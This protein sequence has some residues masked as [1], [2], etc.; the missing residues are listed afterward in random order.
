MN[1]SEYTLLSVGD[2]FSFGQGTI[3]HYPDR[4]LPP[5]EIDIVRQLS[6]YTLL[7]YWLSN[8]SISGYPVQTPNT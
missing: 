8:L 2:S 7:F 5:G 6:N 1:F 4:I 3:E